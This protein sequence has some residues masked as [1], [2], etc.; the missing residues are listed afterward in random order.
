VPGYDAL[1][2]DLDGVLRRWQTSDIEIESAFALPHGSIRTTAFA[3]ELVV[4]AIT[5]KTTDA[6]WRSL[7]AQRLEHRF[8]AAHAADAVQAWSTQTGDVDQRTLSV[9][10]ACRRLVKLVLVTN[11]TSRLT[12]DLRALD[13]FDCFDAIVNSADVGVAKPDAEIFHVALRHVGTTAQRAL[14]IDDTP[15]NVLAAQAVGIKA[16]TF[17][18]HEP[19]SA[20]LQSAGVMGT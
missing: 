8:G 16:H 7:T 20:F 6:Q 17:V 3:P 15:A 1:L 9:L 12:D 5:G 14:F 18:G 4:P 13:L 10:S 11:A 2:V 19:M